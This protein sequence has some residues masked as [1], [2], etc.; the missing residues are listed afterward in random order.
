[1][2]VAAVAAIAAVVI[3]VP[4]TVT[5]RFV[6][7]PER[8][9]DPVRAP[10]EGTVT[11]VFVA[12]ATPVRQRD[13]LFTVSSDPALD[14]G[15]DRQTLEATLAGAPAARA[16]LTTQV[17]SVHAADEAERRRLDGRIL[18]L[19]RSV[20]AK[21]LQLDI[22]RDLEQRAQRGMASGVATAAELAN[23]R[24]S[25]SRTEDE[26]SLAEG[27][28]EDAHAAR[29]RLEFEAASREA[30]LRD[31]SRRLDLEMKQASARL[32]AQ[33]AGVT[34][35]SGALVV[36][37]SCDGMLIR[38]HVRA[39]GAVVQQGDV[40]A[41]LACTS[42]SLVAEV[43]VPAGGI[44]RVQKGQT[45]RLLYDAFPY[46]RYGVRFGELT[47]VGASSPAVTGAAAG[48]AAG[49]DAAGFLARVRP[50]DAHIRVDGV[51]RTLVPGMGGNARIVVAR[52]RLVSYAFEPFRQLREAAADRAVR[53]KAR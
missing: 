53:P 42:D 14:R 6:L 26:L 43:Q 11:R 21:R 38:L 40:L 48:V 39:T 8:G 3:K 36:R 27:D 47:W 25:A 17:T 29:A 24:L 51:E 37:S 31:R 33:R 22:A 20:V 46:Q 13:T 34:A 4:E 9:A 1:M 23:L 19:E 15:A 5:G 12:E 16:D 10:R 44:G 49:A 50:D 45:V 18:T 7:V 35:P 52:R 41:D 28:L 32:D 30:D 2:V